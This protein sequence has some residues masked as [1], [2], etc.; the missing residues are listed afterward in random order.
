MA[1]QLPPAAADA[2]AFLEQLLQAPPD[3]RFAGGDAREFAG[4]REAFIPWV[5][6]LLGQEGA[7]ACEPAEAR[8]LGRQPWHG[9]TRVELEYVNPRYRLLVPVTV[10]EPPAGLRTGA[11]VLCQHGHGQFGRLPVIGERSSREM[12]DELDRHR[13]DYGLQLAQAGFTVA[14]IDLLNFGARALPRE[15][16]RDKCDKLGVFLS[17]LGVSL[18]AVL[19]SDI[20]H[21]I[22]LLAGWDGVDP[23]RLGMCGLSQGGR[24]TMYA[25]LLDPRIQAAVASGAC[26]TVQDRMRCN[27]LCGAQIVP[28]LMP[29]ADHEDLFG[30]FAPRPLQ[31]QWG[32]EDE[33]IVADYTEPALRQ[34]EQ[35]YRA[36]GHP[37][38]FAVHRFDGG[39]VFAAEPAIAW[40]RQ[41]L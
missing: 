19:I 21:A 18:M 22:T 23:A 35:C 31:L 4:W 17:M 39:H 11:G 29:H 36:A 34:I 12:A 26:N 13:Y 30:A 20:R 5:E 1:D 9:C 14:A 32:A 8:V 10:L 33:L 2:T 28:G 37:E 6:G 40:F 16:N 41:W 38:R 3:R 25:A 27:G 15:P 24:M 7:G